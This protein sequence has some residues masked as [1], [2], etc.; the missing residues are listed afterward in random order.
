MHL[1]YKKYFFFITASTYIVLSS[2]SSTNYSA[3]HDFDVTDNNSVKSQKDTLATIKVITPSGK[4]KELTPRF[5]VEKNQLLRTKKSVVYENIS[6]DNTKSN[7]YVIPE[8]IIAQAV[9]SP[10]G[11]PML[12]AA[13]DPKSKDLIHNN[14]TV[15]ENINKYWKPP[16]PTTFYSLSNSEIRLG[17]IYSKNLKQVNG[18]LLKALKSKNYNEFSYRRVKG[19]YAILTKI[20]RYKDDGASY[21][22]RRHDLKTKN[23]FDFWNISYWKHTLFGDN[24]LFRA[25]IFI[26]NEEG[27]D[28]TDEVASTK[29]VI[30]WVKV[31]DNL[32]PEELVEKK[33][34]NR[35][36]IQVLVYEFSKRYTE[37]EIRPSLPSE[38]KITAQIHLEKTGLMSK[39]KK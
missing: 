20:E 12:I 10:S 26:V 11:E 2:C 35:H 27:V 4:Q 16:N 28:T 8:S 34:S 15:I 13:V 29:D 3:H 5:K 33:F 39:L 31:K 25:F 14:R 6:D 23:R 19:G 36:S 32:F 7:F 21:T 22:K 17:Q 24:D 1:N 38:T 30:N 37:S 18:F 9:A